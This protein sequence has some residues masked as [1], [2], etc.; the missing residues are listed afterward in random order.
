MALAGTSIIGQPPDMPAPQPIPLAQG[1]AP[2]SRS[3]MPRPLEVQIEVYPGSNRW[4]TLD[5]VVAREI[6]YA[7]DGADATASLSLGLDAA[8]LTKAGSIGRSHLMHAI[9]VFS[10]D[11][12]ARIVQGFGPLDVR[13]HFQGYPVMPSIAWSSRDQAFTVSLLSEG[14]ELLRTSPES[15]IVGRY[16]RSNLLGEW[17]VS[18]PDLALVTAL[19]PIFNAE[20]KPNRSRDA[21]DMRVVQPGALYYTHKVHLF[22]PD[23]DPDAEPWYYWQALRYLAAMHVSPNVST[24][25][26]LRDT[27]P[28]LQVQQP[29]VEPHPDPFWR[30]LWQRCD[31]DAIA[32]TNAEEALHLLCD[33]AGCHYEIALRQTGTGSQPRVEHYVRILVPPRHSNDQPISPTTLRMGRPRV[34]TIPRDA[35]FRDTTDRSDYEIAVS[36]RALQANLSID[37][38]AFNSP[39]VLGGRKHYEVTLLLRRGWFPHQF[40]DRTLEN[41]PLDGLANYEDGLD[42]WAK[43]ARSFWGADGTQAGQFDPEYDVLS[44]GGAVPKSLYHSAHPRHFIQPG[45]ADVGRLWVFPDDHRFV[46]IDGESLVSDYA[47]YQFPAALYS[48]YFLDPEGADG[49]QGEEGPF[50]GLAYVS[51][52]TGGQVADARGWIPRPR[53]FLETIARQSG[54]GGRAPI[55]EFSYI[56]SSPGDPI[57]AYNV[58]ERGDWRPYGG[59]AQ[60]DP[61]R[62]ALRI[63]DGNLLH[64]PYLLFDPTNPDGISM[65]EALIGVVAVPD[66]ANPGTFKFVAVE[67][68]FWVRVTCVVEGDDRLL[69]KRNTPGAS[70]LRRRATIVDTGSDRFVVRNRRDQNSSLDAMG[71]DPDREYE[72]RDDRSRFAGFA[73]AVGDDLVRS[74]V[75]GSFE[76]FYLDESHRI[77]DVFSG[78]EGLAIQFES[79]TTVVSKQ[80]IADPEA[81]YRTILH[82]SDLRDAPELS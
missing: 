82:L 17:S 14:Q 47:R 22:T 18:N 7:I 12:R 55:V 59:S 46:S 10:P 4:V 56:Q 21:Y 60:L 78:I 52:K 51:S 75:A 73:E 35:P 57:T 11:R 66:E 63:N 6:T 53:P 27:E 44:G 9:G 65:L 50:I 24:R 49:E 33:A 58:M 81:G 2:T 64:D 36:G 5:R 48:P 67:P 26:L 34:F 8:H 74:T 80:F 42:G 23:G 19:L 20:G 31:D 43:T 29:P 25:D 3:R 54:S 15:Q 13:V 32:S 70:F 28:F 62:A 79:W 76:V 16:I 68:F 61:L 77:G 38:A 39:I 69:V 71:T 1:N 72:T 40:L 30:R 37:R 41:E 45:Y